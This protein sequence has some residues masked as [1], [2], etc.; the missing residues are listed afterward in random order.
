MKDVSPK[1]LTNG[2]RLSRWPE[3]RFAEFLTPNRR[4]YNLGSTEDANLVGMRLYGG[5][6]FH[7]ELKP[8]M[9][10]RKK[11]HFI[12]RTDDV[13]YNKLFAW[14]G[15][16]GIV[17][18]DFDGM[19]VSDKF[20][21]YHLDEQTVSRR[22]LQWYFKY[23][24]LWEQAQKMSVGSAA[25]S[26][27]TLNPPR[28]LDL[29]IPL[30]PLKEQER[31]ADKIDGLAN[32]IDRCRTLRDT[33][34]HE[35]S[36]LLKARLNT[37]ASGFRQLGK[38]GEV[39]DGKPRNGWSARC[40]NVEGGTPVLTL[41]A[42]TGFHY[43]PTAYKRTSLP[44]VPDAHYWVRK[45]DLLMSRSNT[46]E[47]VGHAAICNGQPERCIYPDLVMRIPVD[48]RAAD[49]IF[50]WFWLQA[51]LVREFIIANAKGTSPTMKKISQG[52]VERIPFPVGVSLEQQQK[53]V[54]YFKKL[55]EKV[56]RL[57]SLQTKTGLELDA[58]LPSIL[59]KAF[60]GKL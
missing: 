3:V 54:T 36:T 1:N 29:M 51:P 55:Q 33:S 52:T 28:F 9:K 4:P 23:P 13:I 50:V 38:F 12:I 42:V 6:P 25:L 43:D 15:T 37:L 59:D 8:A 20:P 40:D 58:M 49:K 2:L 14:K 34:F 26:K 45:G 53:I 31:I 10:I 7:R 17:P 35:A 41:S 27:L 19:C 47:L 24:P 48:E 56:V 60:K 44:T 39:L 18:D 16:F 32:R 46:P 5:G 57:V 22:Y 30:P 21:T 11:S